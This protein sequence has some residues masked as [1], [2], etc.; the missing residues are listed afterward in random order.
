MIVGRRRPLRGALCVLSLLCAVVL[1]APARADNPSLLPPMVLKH[2]AARLAQ[3]LPLRILAFGSSSTEGVGASSPAASYP[4]CLLKELTGLLPAGQHVSVQN[5]GVGGEDADDMAKRLPAVIAEH[6]DLI[7]WQT[8][9]NDALRN[10]PVDRFLDETVAGVRA[11]RAAH[12]D[13]MLMEPQLSK[14]L[15]GKSVTTRYRDTLRAIGAA[16]E[17]P[18]IRRYDLMRGW[19]ADGSLTSAQMLSPD[20]LHMADGGY[21]KLAEVVADDILR[22]AASPRIAAAGGFGHPS[23]VKGVHQVGLTTTE[24]HAAPK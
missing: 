19:L 5:R 11:I 4:S 8:G 24:L 6:P 17:V 15:D 1:A 2:V 13:L 16:M 18:V 3:H 10:V 9:S 21:A 23:L 14:E 12:I 20:G 7:I 22:D